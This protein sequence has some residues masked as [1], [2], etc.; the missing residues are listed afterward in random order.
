QLRPGREVLL[1]GRVTWDRGPR[2]SGPEVEVWEDG[3][4][5]THLHAER[6]VPV[7]SLTKRLYPTTMRELVAK[8][9]DACVDECE[10]PIPPSILAARGLSPLPLALRDIHFPPS[11]ERLAEAQRRLAYEELLM[12][13]V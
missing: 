5:A 4:E 2:M 11:Y 10:D 7:H 3:S 1:I 8:A 6:I 12:L 13:Q 9:V